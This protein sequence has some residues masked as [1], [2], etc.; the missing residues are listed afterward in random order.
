MSNNLIRMALAASGCAFVLT[1]NAQLATQKVLTYKMVAAVAEGAMDACLAMG[2][3]VSVTVVGRDG[4]VLAQISSEGAAP[5]TMELSRRKAYT[6]LTFHMPS[7]N[8][9]K[10]GG[11]SQLEALPGV[12]ALPG[13]IPIMS[14]KEVIGAVGISGSPGKDPECSQAGIDRIK[15]QL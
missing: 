1:A 14:G 11:A 13:G 6:A 15:D 2:Y 9:E 5:H 4:L 12:T 10:H 8:F 7:A 3:Q